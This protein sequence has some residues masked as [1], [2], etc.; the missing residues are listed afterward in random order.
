MKVLVATDRIG[1]LSPAEASDVVAAAFARQ[2]A[3]VAVAPVATQGPDL[4]AAIGRFAPRAR[5]ARPAGLGHLLDA[6]RSGAEYLD[7]TGLPIPTLPELESLPLLELTAAPVAV[8]AAEYAT[9]PLTGLTGALAEQ[10]RRGDRDLAEVVAED[11]RATGWLDRIGVVDG[12]GTG[13]LGGLGAW[14]RGCGIS[15]STGVQVVA[16]G[17]DLPRLA[18]LADLVV[19]GADTLDFHTRGGEVVRAVTGIAGEALSPVVVICGRNFVSARELRHTGIEE[20]HAVR[21]GLDESPVRDRELEEL[22][23]RVATT[24]QW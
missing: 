11:T 14:L 7:L 3:D 4:S 13:A 12:P 20:A 21:A 9:L 17:Y 18:G 10:G 24:W 8:V 19:T 15:V 16:E 22:A 23:A 6:I 2:G 1:R 5:V